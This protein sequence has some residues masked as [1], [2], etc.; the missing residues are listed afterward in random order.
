MALLALAPVT[1]LV[2][3]VTNA[4]KVLLFLLSWQKDEPNA[5]PAKEPAKQ[6]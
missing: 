5:A 4:D 3:Y 6:R 1:I 2:N